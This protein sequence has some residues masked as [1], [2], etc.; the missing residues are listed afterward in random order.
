MVELLSQRCQRFIRRA[1]QLTGTKLRQ[2]KLPQQRCD[3]LYLE[4]PH[5]LCC[6]HSSWGAEQ[7]WLCWVC[8]KAVAA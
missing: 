2:S 6:K 3:R 7:L 1:W 8:A 5:L 4:S